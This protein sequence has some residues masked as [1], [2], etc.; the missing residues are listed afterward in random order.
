MSAER[1]ALRKE[2]EALKHHPRNIQKCHHCRKCDCLFHVRHD[3]SRKERMELAEKVD[4]LDTKELERLKQRATTLEEDIETQRKSIETDKA[5][6]TPPE[7]VTAIEFPSH[8]SDMVRHYLLREEGETAYE[9]PICSGEV[10]DPRAR[11]AK[12]TPS[13]NVVPRVA[14]Q[15]LDAHKMPNSPPPQDKS[16]HIKPTRKANISPSA[17]I[18]PQ[19]TN[20]ELD[21]SKIPKPPPPQDRSTPP[22]KPDTTP[23]NPPKPNTGPTPAPAATPETLSAERDATNEEMDQIKRAREALAS[24][25]KSLE[26]KSKEQKKHMQELNAPKADQTWPVVQG[27]LFGSALAFGV[28]ASIFRN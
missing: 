18:V 12:I 26:A 27:M 16:T 21:S 6:E 8:P 28:M 17:N 7:D 3:M 22:T 14:N 20:Q 24:R 15:A 5:E 2:E 19:V 23:S 10:A 25:E 11:K 13:T 9:C 1:E 4:A